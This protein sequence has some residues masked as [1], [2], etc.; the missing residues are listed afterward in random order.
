ML[1]TGPM[2]FAYWLTVPWHPPLSDIFTTVFK[3]PYSYGDTVDVEHDVRTLFAVA[4]DS[5][6]FSDLEVICTRMLP[7]DELYCLTWLNLLAFDRDAV[8]QH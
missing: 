1:K 3:L 5:H 7:V 2:K 4:I 6:L 8:T